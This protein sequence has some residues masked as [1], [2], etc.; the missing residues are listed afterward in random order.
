MKSKKKLLLGIVV[1]LALLIY[2]FVSGGFEE[3]AQNPEPQEAVSELAEVVSEV[4]E[5]HIIEEPLKPAD[6]EPQPEEIIEPETQ[7]EQAPEEITE[8]VPEEAPEQTPEAILEEAA[9]EETSSVTEDGQYTSKEEVAEYL[10]RF[11]H[12]PSNYLTKNEAKK[13][14]CDISKTS[15][16]KVLP[17]RSIGGDRFGNFEGALPEEKGRKYFECDIDYKKGSRN[18]KRIIYSNDG[19]IYYTE[20]HYETFELLYGEE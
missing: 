17:G 3:T 14:G 6:P 4:P 9:E 18:A 7:P 13:L 16:S 5:L 19:L 12:L 1:V 10:H 8:E 20:D 2:S 15:L 11:G